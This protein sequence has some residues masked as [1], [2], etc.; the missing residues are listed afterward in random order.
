MTGFARIF[1]ASLL[2]AAVCAG[3]LGCG[4]RQDDSASKS[5][6][7]PE[8][9]VSLA[10][11]LTEIL[12]ALGLGDKV[13]AVSND[14]DYPPQA[15]ARP[16][17]GTFW[18]PNAEAVIAHK[19]DLVVTLGTPQQ[20]AVADTL[21]RLGINVLA[22]KIDTI[23]ELLEAIRRI[24]NAAGCF[25]RAEQLVAQINERLNAI[26]ARSKN[27]KPVGVLWVI[28]TEPLRLAGRRTFINE[29]IELTGGHNAIGQTMAQYPAIGSEQILTSRAEVIIQSAMGT[30]DIE[31]QQAAAENFWAKYADLPAVRNA[32]VY[33]VQ[34]DTILRLGP[35]LPQGAET[36]AQCLHPEH[37][38]TPQE[39]SSEQGR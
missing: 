12:F 37:A 23:P 5:P 7:T 16:K 21:S 35:R 13:V 19:P 2:F 22:V 17:V 11:N 4:K 10:P 31:G 28:Q 18:Q 34:P 14:S 8:R 36:I 9:I 25:E 3:V 39:S 6:G 24:G 15:A 32:R 1:F 20:M 38:G 33:V 30:N 26:R 29:L 27:S